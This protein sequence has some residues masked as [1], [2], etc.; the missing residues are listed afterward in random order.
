MIGQRRRHRAA[1]ATAAFNA[2]AWREPWRLV[3][4]SVDGGSRMRSERNAAVDPSWA[5][6]LRRRGRALAELAPD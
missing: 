2:V 3:S 6:R 5:S 1:Q 4:Y